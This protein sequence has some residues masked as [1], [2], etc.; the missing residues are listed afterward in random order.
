MVGRRDRR[1]MWCELA[2]L[3]VLGSVVF[4][5]FTPGHLILAEDIAVPFGPQQWIGKLHAWTRLINTG[6]D[7]NISDFAG[8]FFHGLQAALRTLGQSLTMAQ[9]LQFYFWFLLPGLAMYFLMTILVKPDGGGRVARLTAAVFYMFNLHLEPIWQL[10]DVA[11]L[12]AYATL[13]LVLGWFA[14]GCATPHR[15]TW[16]LAALTP[17][18]VIGSGAGVNPPVQLIAASVLPL[19]FVVDLLARRYGQSAPPLGG[20]L[21]FAAFVA[22]LWI[23]I[24]LYWLLP[25]GMKLET[26]ATSAVAAK[27]QTL[28]LDW[29]RGLSANTS[30]WNVIRFQG[31]WTWYDGWKEPYHTYAAAFRTNPALVAISWVAPAL[32]AAGMVSVKHPRHLFFTVLTVLGVAFGMGMHPPTTRLYLWCVQHLPLFW[33]IRGPYY[34]FGLF[35][36]LGYAFFLGLVSQ[37]GYSWLRARLGPAVAIASVVVLMTINL[38]YAFPVTI[39]KMYPTQSERRYLPPNHVAIPDYVWAASRWLDGQLA[40]SGDRVLELPDTKSWFYD[41]GLSSSRPVLVQVGQT[42]VLFSSP[43]P[44]VPTAEQP[45]LRAFYQA[46]YQGSSGHL[47]QITRVLNVRYLVHETDLKYWIPNGDTDDPPFV[48][49]CLR[50]QPDFQPQRTFGPWEF[51]EAPAPLPHLYFVPRATLVVGDSS[52]LV[53]LAALGEAEAPA[54]LFTADTDLDTLKALH[55]AQA[56]D[57]LVLTPAAALPLDEPISP[58]P[59]QLL[60]SPSALTTVVDPMRAAPL[61]WER[62]FDSTVPL[63]DGTGWRDLTSNGETNA[64]IVN[65]DPS[66]RHVAVTGTVAAYGMTRNLYLYLNKNLIG[67]FNAPP[68]TRTT[69][70]LRDLSLPPGANHLMFYAPEEWTLLP[71]GRHVNFRFA[72]DW[73]FGPVAYQ[74]TVPVP[75][76]GRWGVMLRPGPLV[77]SETAPPAVWVAGQACTWQ[78]AGSDW[79]AALDLPAGPASL[80]LTGL[81]TPGYVLQLHPQGQPRSLGPPLT[82]VTPQQA[83]AT[84]YVLPPI[85]GPG[86]VVLSEGYH[87]QWQATQQHSVLRHC[88]LQGFANAYWL[89]AGPAAPIHIQFLPQRWFRWGAAFSAGILVVLL[90]ITVGAASRRPGV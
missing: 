33:T 16:C 14:E 39:G 69:V 10:T 43:N 35:V 26:M 40:D 86:F 22:L 1:T 68:D 19:Y 24:N 30:F 46:L 42:P 6:S 37:Q 20:T 75:H 17:V 7:Y 12:A 77:P 63:P 71:D 45:L 72:N 18:F 41:W 48:R 9:R 74:G 78:R 84:D 36:T 31:H 52:A 51:Y 85:Q 3:V 82:P 8:L 65:Q 55:R 2:F 89:P 32:V 28:S 29:L 4:T 53:S 56:L 90:V 80:T 11:M 15:R 50:R 81:E 70:F 88:S 5:W 87:P 79:I 61:E 62:G 67:I 49:A 59:V 25:L 47:G 64:T 54:Y 23:G 60:V 66:V 13:P 21:R 58:G 57:G 27:A 38:T 44:F 73:Q 76:A 83:S 34:K